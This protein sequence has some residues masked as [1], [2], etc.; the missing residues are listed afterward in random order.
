MKKLVL[1]TLPLLCSVIVRAQKIDLQQMLAQGNIQ[2]VPAA[3]AKNMSDGDKKG[4]TIKNDIWLAGID[5][6][7][8]TIELDIRGRN[9][10]LHSFPGIAFHAADTSKNYDVVYFRP[11]NFR[12]VDP[13]RRTWSVQY[14]SLPEYSYEKLRKEDTGQFESEIL[15]NPKPEDWIHAR[16]VISKDNI[17][18]YVNGMDKPS[19]STR[20]LQHRSN[21][22]LGLWVDYTTAD[23]ANLIIT[24]S[25]E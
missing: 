9:E 15:P 7:Y 8:G 11:F 22:M 13:V 2:Q 12:H 20:V 21:G 5:F 23:F 17:K 25:S 1:L 19:L 16:I 14:M 10:F 6:S 24:K 18:V 4:I 3:E